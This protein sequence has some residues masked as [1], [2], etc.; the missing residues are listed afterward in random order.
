VDPV[1][2][3]D[4]QAR[5]AALEAAGSAAPS[6]I[7]ASALEALERRVAAAEALARDAHEQAAAAGEAASAPAGAAAQADRVL[8]ARAI[9]LVAL[10][11]AAQSDM[12]FEAE[13]AA[14]AR[15]WP[16]RPELIAM[17]TFARAGAPDL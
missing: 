9:A 11:D 15:V 13:R 17:A 6:E 1:I 16:G 8:A 10:T 7:D 12:S 3:Q 5:I 4:F 14:L 2:L